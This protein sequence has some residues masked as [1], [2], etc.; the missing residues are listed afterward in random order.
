MQGWRTGTFQMLILRHYL[1][2]LDMEDAHQ[3]KVGLSDHDV[4][5]QWSFFAVFDGHAGSRVATHSAENLL[6]YLL[7]TPEFKDVSFKFSF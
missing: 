4:F 1:S 6:E 2:H 3:V 5:K 7:D